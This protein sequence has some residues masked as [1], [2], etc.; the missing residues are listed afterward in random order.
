M[1][2][3]EVLNTKE[4]ARILTVSP[5]TLWR[6]YS[7]G[8]A[9]PVRTGP[10]GNLRWPKE[11]VDRLLGRQSSEVQPEPRETKFQNLHARLGNL[12]RTYNPSGGDLHSCILESVD[13]DLYNELLAIAQEGLSEV[14]QHRELYHDRGLYEDGTFWYDLCL[15]VTAAALTAAEDRMQESIPRDVVTNLVETLVGLAEHSTTIGTG[16]MCRRNQEALGNTLYA[17][18]DER[19][20]KLVQVKAE[21]SDSE[22]VTGFIDQTVELVEKALAEP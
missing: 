21:I 5:L 14:R 2:P 16:E 9:Y 10:N 20:V 1:E 18:H 15:I 12:E 3:P 11:E 17:F 13:A 4:A 7:N 22:T 19:L 8:L 6:W